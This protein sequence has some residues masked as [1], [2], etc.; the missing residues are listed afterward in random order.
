MQGLN[1]YS[2]SYQFNK[3]YLSLYNLHVLNRDINIIQTAPDAQVLECLPGFWEVVSSIHSWVIPNTRMKEALS[4]MK[5]STIKM[6]HFAK[7]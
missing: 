6:V 4:I 7:G 1:E 5:N 2:L 3:E